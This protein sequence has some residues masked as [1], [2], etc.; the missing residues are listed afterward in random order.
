MQKFLDEYE[1]MKKENQ[2]MQER[3]QSLQKQNLS[4]LQK[5]KDSN[6]NLQKENQKLANSVKE[7][8]N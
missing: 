3:I 2:E 8:K 5:E 6:A 7:L 4:Q 1:S